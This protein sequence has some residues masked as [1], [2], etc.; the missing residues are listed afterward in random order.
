M[1]VINILV[2][3]GIG[4]SCF[5]SVIRGNAVSPDSLD[6]GR[7]AVNGSIISS[8]GLVLSLVPGYA[9]LIK[10]RVHADNGGICQNIAGGYLF[11]HLFNISN[12]KHIDNAFRLFLPDF[13]C[14][15]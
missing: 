4:L 14:G 11:P 13:F 3:F 2:G 15:I 5:A 9:A 6:K 12:I 10:G 1:A 7:L 8:S